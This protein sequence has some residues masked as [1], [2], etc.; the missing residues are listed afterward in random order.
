MLLLAGT[1]HDG[2][3]VVLAVPDCPATRDLIARAVGAGIRVAPLDAV[4]PSL[5][6]HIARLTPDLLHVHAGIGWEG[7]GMTRA[8][9][10][11][12]LPVLRTEHL[13]YLLTDA[14]QKAAYAE[15]LGNCTAVVAVSESSAETYGA[16]GIAP[17]KLHVIRNG[18]LPGGSLQDRASVRRALG[19]TAGGTLLLS[20]A[21]LAPQKGHAVLL[22][23]FSQLA[24]GRPELRLALVGTGE[25]RME[26]EALAAELGLFGRVDFLG[27]REDVPDLLRAA[28]LF[29]LP[30]LFEG[31]PLAL[32]EAMAAGVPAV[33]TRIGGTLEAIGADHPLLCGAGDIEDLA[34]TIAAALDDSAL[35]WKAASAAH[36]RFSRHF[37]ADRMVSETASLYLRLLASNGIQRESRM[38]RTRIGFIGAGGI[39]NRHLGVLEQFHDVELVAFSDTDFDRAA[40]AAKRF[41]ARAFADHRAMLEAGGLDAV[42][43]CVPPFAHGAIEM[44]LIAAK[45]PFFVEKPLSLDIETAEHVARHVAQSGLITAV[46]Y[47]WRYLDI[48]DEAKHHLADNPARLVSGYWLDA[49]PPPQWWWKQDRSGGQIVEQTT[50]ILDLARWLVGDVASVFGQAQHSER[51]DFPGLDVATASTASLRFASGAVGNIAST[52]LLRWGH[53]I[54]LHLFADGLAIELSDREIMVDVGRGRPVRHAEGDPVRREDRDFIDAVRGGDNRIRCPYGEALETHRVALAVSQ[55]AAS[56]KVIDLSRPKLKTV[57]EVANV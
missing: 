15:A 3:E 29:V 48:V 56:G 17:E 9:A 22:R 10:A 2:F 24:A 14:E 44:D 37:H 47:H 1:L 21:R 18:I 54:G 13:P 25:G 5:E 39:A 28:D 33:A 8:G 40:E 43:V 4:A 20:V 42:Y 19:V 34:A 31:L 49:T 12:G 35:T 16:A 50:H 6:G 57:R 27:H 41:G 30:S 11:A 46:G 55:S 26:T 36:T 38:N 52:C 32:L 53:R 51:P 45:L 23:A 7:H